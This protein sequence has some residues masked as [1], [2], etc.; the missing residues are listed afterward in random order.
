MLFLKSRIPRALR[1][2]DPYS[3]EV[4]ERESCFNVFYK[5]TSWL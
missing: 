2:R 1:V 4:L 5:G 3:Y